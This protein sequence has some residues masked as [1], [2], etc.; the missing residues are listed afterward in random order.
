MDA[1]LARRLPD[2]PGTELDPGEILE[3]FVAYAEEEGLE[4]YPAQEEAILELLEGRH[5]VLE[6]PT[7]SGK[8]LVALALHFKA[9]CEGKTSWYTSPIKAL[10]NEKF[11]ALCDAFGPERVGLMT[12]D[13]SINRDAP[14][15]CC[16][17][18]ILSN[19]ALRGETHV[20]T[21]VMDEFHYYGDRDRGAAWQIPLLTLE[22]TAFLLMSATLGNVAPITEEIERFTGRKVAHVRST[23]RPVP[24]TFEYRDVPLHETI[25][26][27]LAQGE[28]PVYLVNFSQRECPEQAQNL[29]SIDICSKEEKQALSQALAEAKFDTPQGKELRRFLAHGIGL[30]HAG[31]L[32]R[33]RRLVERLAKKGLLKVIS[34][35]DTLGV[36]VNIPLRTVLLTRLFKY[37]GEKNRLLTVR[38]LL[39]IAGRAGRK[40]YDDH[41]R[42]VAQAPEHVIENLRLDQ[43]AARRPDLKKKIVKKKPPPGFVSW[44]EQVFEGLTKRPPE[45]LEPVF[46]V[47]HGM[48]LEVLQ[49]GGGAR[50]GGYRRLLDILDRAHLRPAQKLEQKRLA[51]DR[52]RSLRRAG[53]VEVVK[54]EGGPRLEVSSEL[55]EDFSLNHTLALWLVDVVEHLDFDAEAYPLDVLSLVEAILEDPRPVLM[56]QVHKLKG[57][58]LMRLK[59]EGVEYDERMEELQKVEHPKPLADFIYG[60]F[61]AFA[62]HH[63]WV[64]AE[65]IRPKGVARELYEGLWTFNDYVRWY[66][67][68]RFE[69]VL[70][71][72]LSDA[73]KTY[74]QGVPEAFQSEATL[75]VAAYLRD[76]LRRVDASLVEEWER[77]RGIE[78]PD[79]VFLPEAAR[80]P[81]DPAAD[82]RTFAPRVRAEVQLLLKALAVK[83][84]E[85]AA[86]SIRH[87]RW[88]WSPEQLA[89]LMG[90]YFEVHEAVDLTPRARQARMTTIIPQGPRKWTVTHAVLDPEGEDDWALHCEIDLT[91]PLEDEEAP[92]IEL[93]DIR[94]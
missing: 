15:V 76:L 20:D 68:E 43:K 36:G 92:L 40:G 44:D 30:H 32:P 52:M 11:F 81:R 85:E 64:G 55:Q 23:D 33:Y 91:E 31:L 16:T 14:I 19:A 66:G 47:T 34:G 12:G 69:G 63:P 7:G 78:R 71:R 74:L 35:T 72:Y 2:A 6:T 93:V 61:D 62:A 89:E 67:L 48:L 50:D 18:E 37:D 46:E 84:W 8:S 51:A 41:G 59:A 79:E 87:H 45:P 53:I 27:L 22:D 75:E 10:V 39:Q 25:Q 24:L 58:L 1:P 70:L 26:D 94:P 73:Y 82:P 42:V 54:G 65:N 49:S 17:A 29:M 3:R 9:L 57:E 13:A 88:E 90:R 5:V 60:T 86:R 56:S 4:L 83:D 21:V 77:M 28:A 80:R 38:E